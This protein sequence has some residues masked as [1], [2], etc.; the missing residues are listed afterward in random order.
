MLSELYTDHTYELDDL[1]GIGPKSLPM[2]WF[3]RCGDS[4]SIYVRDQYG[5]VD[6]DEF[7]K[8]II[9]QYLS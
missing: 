3:S 5:D 6:T 2:E 7:S 1:K 9:S 4:S 8:E